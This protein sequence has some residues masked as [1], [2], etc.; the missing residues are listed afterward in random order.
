MALQANK[1]WFN[2]TNNNHHQ[3]QTMAQQPTSH[4]EYH[5]DMDGPAH[6]QTYKGFIQFTQI[7]GTVALCWVVAL[8]VGSLKQAWISCIVGVVLSLAA[9]G[10]GALSPSLGW[11][12]ALAVLVMLL[13]MLAFY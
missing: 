8:G 7:I 11:R 10:L 3:D 9:G 1:V 12:P 4:L 13:A 5:P 2:N 6:E